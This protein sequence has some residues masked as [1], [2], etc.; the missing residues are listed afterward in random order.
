MLTLFLQHFDSEE[1]KQLF[2][3]I[4][5]KYEA[6]LLKVAT[7][8]LYDKSYIQDCIQDTFFELSHSFER[9]KEISDENKQKSYLITICKRCAIKINNKNDTNCI[10]I[11][12]IAEENII[13]NLSYNYCEE[14]ISYITEVICKM[15]EKYSEPLIMK[16]VD[17]YSLKEISI[18]LGITVA[19]VKQRLF[20]GKEKINNYLR[21][22]KL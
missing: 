16:Y 12:D 1:D 18:K 17:G 7:D 9:F 14:N 13:N 19:T 22:E 3:N 8:K 2:T 5:I 11:E 6:Y 15:D 21:M 10:S 20:R 4:Y